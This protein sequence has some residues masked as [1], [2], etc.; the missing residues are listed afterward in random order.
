VA[1]RHADNFG[2]QWPPP[3]SAP[4][5]TPY[6]DETARCFSPAGLITKLRYSLSD[7]TIDTLCFMRFHLQ[8]QNGYLKGQ[9]YLLF[10]N[11]KNLIW[12]SLRKMSSRHLILGCFPFGV[13]R[14][15]RIM[16]Q[17]SEL[18]YLHSEK[19]LDS[20]GLRISQLHTLLEWT[21]HLRT[22]RVFFPRA[23]AGLSKPCRVWWHPGSTSFPV[24]E[25]YKRFELRVEC[26]E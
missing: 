24:G 11:F 19:W 15:F 2:G 7:Y 10:D 8:Y 5:C 17:P 14:A 6:A 1:W 12:P 4:A 26:L 20:Q 3:S 22:A 16:T 18:G 25:N 13:I 21:F 9:N 23:S